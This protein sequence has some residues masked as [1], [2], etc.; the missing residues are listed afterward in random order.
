M[1]LEHH[2]ALAPRLLDLHESISSVKS[3]VREAA[4]RLGE[5]FAARRLHGWPTIVAAEAARRWLAARGVPPNDVTPG[6]VARLVA[7]ATD[8]ATPARETFA[9][10]IKVARRNGRIQAMV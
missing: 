4:P 5:E 7:M 8:A 1:I 9:G 10:S 6:A 2:P 3:W